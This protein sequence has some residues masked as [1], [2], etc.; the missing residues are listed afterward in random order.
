[1]HRHVPSICTVGDIFSVADRVL[2]GVSSS[3][4]TGKPTYPPG[5]QHRYAMICKMHERGP[6]IDDLCLKQGDFS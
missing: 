2:G 4:F 6:F 1:M 3:P 5:T